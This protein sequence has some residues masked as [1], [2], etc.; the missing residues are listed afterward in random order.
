MSREKV[1]EGIELPPNHEK[2]NYATTVIEKFKKRVVYYKSIRAMSEKEY[3][4]LHELIVQV[5]EYVGELSMP[6]FD[7]SDELESR[8]YRM[9]KHAPELAKKLYLEHYHEIHRPF[10]TL[11]NRCFTLLEEM[12]KNYFNIN[13]RPPPQ[14]Y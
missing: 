3:I 9:Y 7:I 4:D 2:L 11:K 10:N 14:D 5:L 12:D 1:M 13:H 6:A 8:Y